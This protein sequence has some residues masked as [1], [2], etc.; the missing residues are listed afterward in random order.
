MEYPGGI[1]HVTARGNAGTA[2]Y[3]DESDRGTFLDLLGR[4]VE[5]QG[6]RCFAFCLM[7]NHYHLL[8]QTPE[9]NLS[10]GMRRLNG[11]Y[12]Q[13]FNRRHR[14]TGHLLQGRFKSIVI[15]KDS[16]LKEL[17]RY[18]VLN[19]VRAGMVRSTKDW[20]WSSYRVTAGQTN[21]PKW[22]DVQAVLALFDT[23]R[24]TACQLYRRFVSEGK[25][26]SS[27]WQAV[28]GQIFLGDEAFLEEMQRRLRGQTIANVPKQQT[29]PT[30]LGQ[31]EVLRR[32]SEAYQ[33]EQQAIL[34]RSHPDAYQCAAWLLRRAANLPLRQVAE[35]FGVSSSRISHIQRQHETAEKISKKQRKAMRLCNIKR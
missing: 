34:T 31:A 26:A 9:A 28:K 16:Y 32:V 17:C 5:Q 30:R 1:Y 4:E 23:E 3:L 29:Q 20:R 10:R 14:R 6:W 8:L 2:I 7:D 19:P 25:G 27:P 18:V 35:L 11:V 15:D 24:K 22:L 21:T 13:R 33:T 12:T